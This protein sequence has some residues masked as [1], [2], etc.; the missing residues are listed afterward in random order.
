MEAYLDNSATT[1]CAEPVI[2]KMLKV[3]REDFGNPSSMHT[4]G[5]EAEHYVR[6]AAA[7]IADSLKVEPKNILFT[8]GGTESNNTAIIG[9]ALSKRREGKHLI[10]TAIEHASVASPMKF[11]EEEGFEVTRIPVDGKGQVDLEKLKSA[12]R[13]DTILVSIMHVNN[14]IGAVEP[15]EEIG[16][17][18]KEKNPK[19]L[20]HVDA[21]QSY[22]KFRIRPKKAKIDYLSVSSHKIHGPKG[23]G[24]LYVKNPS[25]LH[26]ILFGGGQQDGLRSGTENVPGIAG[27]GEAASLAYGNLE[28]NRRHLYEL[29]EF[30]TGGL[31]EI[32]GTVLNGPWGPEGAPQ[33]VSASF[34]GVR[35]EVLLHALEEKG[36]Y[37]S[38]GSACSSHKRAPSATLSAIGVRRDLLEST[39]R[40][41]FAVTTQ[42]EELEYTLDNLKEIL[43]RLRK[44][45]RR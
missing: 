18:V 41:S 37:V 10:T 11:L 3:Y 24:F 35:S 31:S 45:A 12:I 28:E 16:Q 4:K 22:G 44:Y 27:L 19:T 36:I 30:F 25:A 9:T 7:A 2:Q 34:E 6:E 33:I 23:V 32:E 38:A 5:L 29:K 26:P 43:P 8:S 21:I 14:E 39:V 1:R 20:F 40:F 17:M 13:E 42:K 15:I